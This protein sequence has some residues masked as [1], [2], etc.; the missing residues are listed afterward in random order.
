VSADDDAWRCEPQRIELA[1]DVLPILMGCR[2]VAVATHIETATRAAFYLNIKMQSASAASKSSKSVLLALGS[3]LGSRTRHLNGA[4]K[5]LQQS[6]GDVVDTSFLYETRP[7]YVT[8]QPSFLNAACRV[9][10]DLPPAQL[11]DQVKRIEREL[12]RV[13]TYRNGPRVIDVDVLSM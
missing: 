3:N 11:L 7:A 13:Q 4:I 6:V 9:I 10:T 2:L 12:G 1:W 5:R 8:E